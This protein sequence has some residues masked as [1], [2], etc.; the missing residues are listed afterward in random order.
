MAAFNVFKAGG[1]LLSSIGE[2]SGLSIGAAT[3]I[4]SDDEIRDNID[5]TFVSNGRRGIFVFFVTATERIGTAP[6]TVHIDIESRAINVYDRRFSRT[7]KCSTVFGISINK[8][9]VTFKTKSSRSIHP[10][11]YAFANADY[12]KF[13]LDILL[14]SIEYGSVMRA[15]FSFMAPS[16]GYLSLDAL[17]FG[18]VSQDIIVPTRDLQCILDLCDGEGFD[19]VDFFNKLRGFH[20]EGLRDCLLILM[21]KA[22]LCDSSPLRPSLL[23]GEEVER[24]LSSVTWR[25][26]ASEDSSEGRLRRGVLTI[27]NYR[28]CFAP[29]RYSTER[30]SRH[31]TP[32]FFDLISVPLNSILKVK[33][34]SSLGTVNRSVLVVRTKDLRFFRV[35]VVGDLE[36]HDTLSELKQQLEAKCF[37]ITTKNLFCFKYKP[38]FDTRDAWLLSSIQF[39]FQRLGLL[40]DPEWRLLPN[41]FGSMIPS[42]PSHFIV[43]KAFPPDD[44]ASCWTFRSKGRLPVLTYRYHERQ[45]CLVRSSQPMIGLSQLHQDEDVALLNAYRKSGVLNELRYEA[46]DMLCL[47]LI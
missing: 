16:R 17:H 15:A 9:T 3:D 42:Y 6:K 13:F 18:M 2:V 7:Y 43:P 19:F 45:T 4:S 44:I 5:P 21:T 31:H 23:G 36:A 34:I 37:A 27:T 40:T 32:P 38:D 33:V 12:A 29:L 28:L 39:D 35:S 10:K 25:I 41:T 24:E 20:V 8:E 1:A 46:C 22:E 11:I 14:T 30:L 26:V 47:L